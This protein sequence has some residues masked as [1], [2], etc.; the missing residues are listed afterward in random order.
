MQEDFF[1]SLHADYL[2]KFVKQFGYGFNPTSFRGIRPPTAATAIML[3][4]MIS[5]FNSTQG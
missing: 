1:S 3:P 4:E 2:T 5:E